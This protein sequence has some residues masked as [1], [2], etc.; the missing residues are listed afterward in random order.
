MTPTLFQI[1]A[2]MM[3]VDREIVT[4]Y[5]LPEM[6]GYDVVTLNRAIKASAGD[7]ADPVE[8]GQA[9]VSVWILARRT[10]PCPLNQR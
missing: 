3:I 8:S 9:G 4:D 10:R 7:D 6:Y 5:D 2:D 1:C